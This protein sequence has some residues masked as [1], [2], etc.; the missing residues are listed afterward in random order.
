MRP[1]DSERGARDGAVGDASLPVYGAQRLDEAVSA[2]LEQ[3]R[4]SMEIVA[5]FAMTALLLAAMG[6]YGVISYI[7]SERTHEIGIRLA[8]G[9]GHSDILR[10]CS[11]RDCASQ[12]RALPSD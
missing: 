5:L 8:L 11:A 4:F 12:W 7:V 1:R 9:A 3:R 10:W 2:S 6:I